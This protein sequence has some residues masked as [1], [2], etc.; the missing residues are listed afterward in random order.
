MIKNN[1]KFLLIVL[2]PAFLQVFVFMLLPIVGTGAISFMEYNPLEKNNHFVG[3]QNYGSLLHDDAFFIALKNTLVFTFV[4][5]ALNIVVSLTMATLISQLKSNKSRSFFRMIVFLPCMAPLVASS[6]VWARSIYQTKGGLA[7]AILI[8]FGGDAISWIG[9]ARFLMLSVIIFT[10]WADM[11]YN[12]I[13]FSAGID[14]IP[15][16][17]YQASQIDGASRWR[18]FSQIT[19][20]LLSRTIT[21][22]SLMTLIS[23]FQMFAQFNVLALKD[24][25]QSSGLVLTSYIYK[26]AFIYKEMG[27]AAAI[28]MVL[29]LIIIIVTVVQQRFTKVD[30]EY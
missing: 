20:P 30:W 1:R 21:F 8:L 29:L 24:G 3:F 25:P 6:V 7:N 13:L 27:Y 12:T 18:T 10:I 23:H 17:I 22:V 9:D 2:I 15:E 14:G 5:V 26:N 11:G 4:T 28:S 19:L 16:D